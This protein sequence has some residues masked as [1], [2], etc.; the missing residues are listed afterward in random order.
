MRSAI[1]DELDRY[2]ILLEEDLRRRRWDSEICD[3]CEEEGDE[4][5]GN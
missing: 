4:T 5:D 2:E 3:A 1:L